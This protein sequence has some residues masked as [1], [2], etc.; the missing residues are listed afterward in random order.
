MVDN[1]FSQ[2]PVCKMSVLAACM[3]PPYTNAQPTK[4]V[5]H[6]HMVAVCMPHGC[7]QGLDFADLSYTDSESL[8]TSYTLVD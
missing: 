4:G 6:E 1:S 2:C 5:P 8:V 3:C 7:T